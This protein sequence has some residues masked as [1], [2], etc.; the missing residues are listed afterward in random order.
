MRAKIL[1]R[2]LPVAIAAL[3]AQLLA[4]SAA[5]AEMSGA[6]SGD[7][8]SVRVWQSP[9]RT[10]PN[11]I[12]VSVRDAS[13]RPVT[14]AEVSVL[15]EPLG[16]AEPQPEA[17]G[18]EAAKPQESGGMGGM[19]SDQNDEA[20]PAATEPQESEAEEMSAK[21]ED[22]EG[23]DG[24][25]AES[26]TVVLVATDNPGTYRAEFELDEPGRW[27]V[28]IHVKAAGER[29]ESSFTVNVVERRSWAVLGAFLGLNALIILGAAMTRPDKKRSLET[30]R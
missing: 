27:H 22:A 1:R 23:E 8:L 16:P 7:A 10:G 4:V 3:I 14:G 25:H 13:G 28:G 19:G 18:P 6:G 29:H 12:E 11:A 15:L 21:G 24:E 20:E 26:L 5:T 17:A 9:P 30:S 2:A